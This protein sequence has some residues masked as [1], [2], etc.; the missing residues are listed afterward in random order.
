[1]SNVAI[2]GI[3]DETTRRLPEPLTLW[4]NCGRPA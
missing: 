2:V 4:R 3:D 1:M